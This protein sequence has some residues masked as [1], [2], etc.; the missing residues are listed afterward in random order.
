M[1]IILF[2]VVVL[3]KSNRVMNLSWREESNPYTDPWNSQQTTATTGRLTMNNMFSD[4]SSSS[5]DE[6]MTMMR[7]QHDE[8]QTT[9]TTTIIPDEEG[10]VPF[11]VVT[12]PSSI[13]IE[14]PISG[15]GGGGTT[16]G[17][18]SARRNRTYT[19][20]VEGMEDPTVK[21]HERYNQFQIQS[22]KKNFV[23][24]SGGPSNNLLWNAVFVC[25][26]TG[27]CFPTGTIHNDNKLSLGW[28]QTKKMAI[29][30][31]AG[32]ADD[33][34]RFREN[35]TS[36]RIPQFCLEPPYHVESDSLESSTGSGLFMAIPNHVPKSKIFEIRILQDEA[37]GG[38]LL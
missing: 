3:W 31:A 26:K 14:S 4:A 28:Y 9:M 32:R 8:R 15:G 30:A 38:M 19:I 1:M 33:C 6:I 13:S 29:K 36:L 11:Q 22:L 23:C 18:S 35:G 20:A 24:W 12:P 7:T 21:L 25:P 37:T 2:V 16:S 17:N 5:H 10:G 27:E 34:F